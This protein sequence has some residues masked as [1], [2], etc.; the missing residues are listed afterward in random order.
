M[1][2]V[3]YAVLMMVVMTACGGGGT[4]GPVAPPAPVLSTVSVSI[5]PSTIQL[6]QSASAT[7]E[8]RTSAGAVLTDRAV[9]W[10]S[11][12]PSVASVDA[13]GVITSVAV[14]T[15]TISATS[16]GKTGAATI[17]V[18]SI[19]V[20]SVSMTGVTTL[21]PGSAS[22]FTALLRDAAGATLTNRAVSWSSSD[23]SVAQV[24]QAGN[25]LAIAPGTTTISATSEGRTG[26]VVV[27]VRYNISTVTFTGA[28]RV[29]VGDSYPYTFT[30]R[31]ADGTVVSPPA[32]WGVTEAGRAVVNSNGMLMPLQAGT[33]TI[34]LLIDG[35]LWTTSI[36]AYDWRAFTSGGSAFVSIEADIAVANRS[37]VNDRPEL[38]LSCGT[39]GYFFLW[40]R[41]PHIVTQN[42]SVAYLF[43]G[44]AAQG[45]TWRELSPDYRT[46]WH[47]G[48]NGSTK[49][50]AA[51]IA[52]SRQF[53]FGFGE[54]MGAT[55]ATIFRV[56]GLAP[57][58]APLYTM[59]PS[60]A[61]VAGAPGAGGDVAMPLAEGAWLMSAYEA[62]RGVPR[63][64]GVSADAAARTVAAPSEADGSALLR[65][66]PV[67][68]ASTV[69]T[70]QAKRVR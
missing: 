18:I 5:S 55:K 68:S 46:L 15:S 31:L 63:E 1:Q 7:A 41:T 20:A 35:G 62:A 51:Q 36:T 60:N 65:A 34:Q 14:G 45:A 53:G 27:T 28:T 52:A 3:A 59:C 30:A 37:G 43:D 13:N 40:V 58:V 21:T 49:N 38:V 25:V 44:G 12:T 70:R 67:W 6:G 48:T 4:D 29:K 56:T 22:G 54:F 9:S 10:S 47:P 57:L 16:E 32:I 39:D 17:T 64:A 8:L 42:G 69:E 66:W 24:S 61:I 26:S 19:P 50:F 23:V 11:A 33:F 2:R